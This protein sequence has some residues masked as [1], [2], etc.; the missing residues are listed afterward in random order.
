M[1]ISFRKRL[2]KLDDGWWTFNRNNKNFVKTLCD[3]ELLY[4]WFAQAALQTPFICALHSTMLLIGK[5]LR[6]T[7]W[8]LLNFRIS[9]R[10]TILLDAVQSAW[11]CHPNEDKC[12]REIIKV[13]HRILSKFNGDMGWANCTIPSTL[14]M[15]PWF[16][17]K[18]LKHH[19]ISYSTRCV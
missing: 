4:K 18:M 15:M 10:A 11:L 13:K 17:T 6:K 2:T 12:A 14:M 3:F 7:L 16:T 5:L 1:H 8:K 9:L 19:R